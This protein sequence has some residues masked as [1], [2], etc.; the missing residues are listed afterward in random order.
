MVQRFLCSMLFL[1]CLICAAMSWSSFAV[2]IESCLVCVVG[3]SGV[4][5]KT[6]ENYTILAMQNTAFIFCVYANASFVAV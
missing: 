1:G 5:F 3:A 2:T 6:K 4:D